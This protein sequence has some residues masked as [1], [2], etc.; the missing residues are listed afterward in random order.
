MDKKLLAYQIS[1]QTV[2]ID[3]SS[4]RDDDLNG[5][6]SFLI[7]NSG[8]TTPDGYTDISS[9][10]NWDRFGN[11]V[12]N[13]YLVTKFEI[14]DI[15]NSVGWSGLTNNEKDLAIKYYINPDMSD[16]FNYLTTTSGMTSSEAQIFLSKKWHIH[17]GYLLESCKER[18]YYV[19]IV[20]IKYLS[21]ADAEDLFDTAQ[22]LVYEYT[23][24]G[25]LGVNYGDKNNGIMDYLMSTNGYAGQGL[26]EENYTLQIGTWNEFKTELENV[27]VKGIY[28]KYKN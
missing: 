18:W 10:E 14:R 21:F 6:D 13:D 2:G 15:A 5:N 27:L 8:D 9:I 23:E 20:A 16:A 7:I 3:L 17:H 1:G 4:W 28:S 22:Q 25:R 19:K 24:M 11:G 12:A 26:E